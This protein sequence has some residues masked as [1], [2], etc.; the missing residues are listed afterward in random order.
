M[1]PGLTWPLDP[2]LIHLNHGSF[3]ATPVEG[4]RRQ[5]ALRDE[6]NAAPVRW[7]TTLPPRLAQAR[8]E[9]AAWLGSQP[10][11]TAFVPN[12]T[13]GATAVFR[14]LHLQPGDEVVVTDHGYGAVN[15]GAARM[16]R[17]AGAHL[18]TVAIPLTASED[19]I[20]ALVA[21][22]LTDRTRLLVIDHVTSATALQLPAA[23]LCAH[24]RARGIVTLVDGAHTPGM[25]A[26]PVVREADVWVG[27]L[28]K[29]GLCPRPAAVLVARPEIGDQLDPTID[30]WGAGLPYP[31]RFD[32]Q[33]TGDVTAALTAPWVLDHV[34][35]V[36]GWDETRRW[37]AALLDE[38]HAVIC[39][40]LASATGEDCAPHVTCPAPQMRLVRLPGF[41]PEEASVTRVRQ[42][43]GPAYELAVTWFGGDCYLRLSAHLHNSVEDYRRFATD[44]VP[45]LMQTRQDA[46]VG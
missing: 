11:D 38:G 15:S 1:H 26:D 13:A 39:E 43:A 34:E 28:H 2:S 3:G 41:A 18:R 10:A 20:C 46:Q 25:L 4:L 40:A 32:H 42:I 45:R 31:D 19:E 33:G 44:V 23:R 27:N 6:M 12:A 7:F 21:A 8:A 16:A 29:W 36:V 35:Q 17:R 22:A 24:A 14:S 9:V 37:S 30:S 5:A